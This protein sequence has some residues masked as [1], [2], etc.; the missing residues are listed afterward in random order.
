MEAHATLRSAQRRE[1]GGLMKFRRGALAMAIGGLVLAAAPVVVTAPAAVGFIC[2]PDSCGRTFSPR[3]TPSPSPSPD[4]TK[5]YGL[6]LTAI[7]AVTNAGLTCTFGFPEVT[8]D[9]QRFTANWTASIQCSGQVADMAAKTVFDNWYFP[10]QAIACSNDICGGVLPDF[11]P[12]TTETLSGSTTL[13]PNASYGVQLEVA[14]TAPPG[15]FWEGGPVI[16][17]GTFFF[18][19]PDAVGNTG[20]TCWLDTG[21]FSVPL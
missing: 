18:C 13:T 8:T 7:T 3:P 4:Q 15:Q 10:G 14:V 2:P 16:T 20:F 19:T 17:N 5:T 1:E 21:P 9:F 12:R 11:G 6:E